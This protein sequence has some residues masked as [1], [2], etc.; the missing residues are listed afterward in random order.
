MSAMTAGGSLWAVGAGPFDTA[1]LAL[2]ESASPGVVVAD[3]RTVINNH[4]VSAVAE[5]SPQTAVVAIGVLEED[6]EIL[7]CAE[8]GVAGLV[9]ANASFDDLV[10]VVVGAGRGEF[11]ASPRMAAAILRHVARQAAQR[12]ERATPQP[13]ALTV[14]E[15]EIVHLV[16]RGKSNKEIAAALRIEVTTA[17]N[18]V[19]RILEKLGVP[20]R[21]AIAHAVRRDGWFFN[22]DHLPS[23][24]VIP[25]DET[26]QHRLNQKV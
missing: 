22:A 25:V 8:A 1:T 9:P 26:L 16:G 21:S 13:H 4:L 20:R 18:H 10:K 2:I 6:S 14:R 11:P 12:E 24:A 19:H 5:L 15:L 23:P 3:S 7:A 17:K